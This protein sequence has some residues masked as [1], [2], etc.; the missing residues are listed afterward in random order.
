MVAT[1]SRDFELGLMLATA[2]ARPKGNKPVRATRF[3]CAS[4]RFRTSTASGPAC[5][6]TRRSLVLAAG[7]SSAPGHAGRRRAAAEGQAEWRALRSLLPQA[8]AANYI[9]KLPKGRAGYRGVAGRG[10]SAAPRRRAQRPNH[11]G[12]HWH[13]AGAQSARRAGV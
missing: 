7:G 3:A 9:Q 6:G 4:Q 2:L 8:S 5:T 1:R 11:D 12:A 10:R 13:A